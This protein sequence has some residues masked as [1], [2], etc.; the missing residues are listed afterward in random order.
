MGKLH[1]LFNERV[2]VS[3]F[4]YICR[5]NYTDMSNQDKTTE[6]LRKLGNEKFRNQNY[7][8]ALMCYTQAIDK[9][10]NNFALYYNRSIT[11]VK[12]NAM[13]EAKED[14]LIST[15]LNDE[16]IPSLCQLAFIYLYEGDTPNSLETYVKIIKINEKLPN[17]LNRF[18]AQLKESIRLCE[19]RCKQQEYSENFIN[20]IITPNIREIINSYPNLPTHMI[21]SG[22][23]PIS[24]GNVSISQ[25][26]NSLSPSPAVLAGSIRVGRTNANANTNNN[27]TNNNGNINISAPN[28]A[29]DIGNAIS[30]ALNASGFAN[31]S[32][33]PTI[34][35][36]TRNADANS[37]NTDTN[38]TANTNTN[39]NTTANIAD[40]HRNAHNEAI[41]TA[42]RRSEELRNERNNNN[43][44]VSVPTQTTES[45]NTPTPTATAAVFTTDTRNANDFSNQLANTITSQLS[46]V[47][48]NQFGT[49]LNPSTIEA[50]SSN[51]SNGVGN[52]AREVINGF[53][54]NVSNSADSNSTNSTSATTTS[55][56]V[57]TNDN[58]N[59]NDN[60][61][62]DENLDLD[63]D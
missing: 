30:Q 19:E 52:L 16:Y 10:P 17:Q 24:F 23:P 41:A 44:P 51:L 45:T 39:A 3:F 58:D 38:T 53:S 6:E 15:K 22:I 33:I 8:G 36:N 32:N 62:L 35:N 26:G 37:N 63:I 21:E 57:S 7:G 11:L 1:V 29:V 50:I 2:I 43:V 61:P 54:G 46:N 28:A 48:N 20:S 4:Y 49:N 14:L 27:G 55:G 60:T 40:I 5:N 25:M 12:M 18:K 59:H 34:I 31:L 47:I 9:E 42:L 56:S 13:D